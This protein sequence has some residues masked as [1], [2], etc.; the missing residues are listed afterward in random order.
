MK[1]NIKNNY[2]N[3]N[4][5]YL[6]Y[7]SRYQEET[8]PPILTQS[9]NYAYNIQEEIPKKNKKMIESTYIKRPFVIESKNINK[10]SYNNENTKFMKKSNN[11]KNKNIQTQIIEYK[12]VKENYSLKHC[13]CVLEYSFREDQNID[14][15]ALMEDKSKIIE[16]FNYDKNQMVFEIFD[17]HG[18]DEMSTYL[19]NNLA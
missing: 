13:N 19:Q 5:Y 10:N 11:K 12:T 15:E 3:E 18:H 4:N 8:E 9:L 14:S 16:N 7:N 1:F 17:G 6:P 2:N